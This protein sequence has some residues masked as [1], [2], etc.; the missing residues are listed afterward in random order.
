MQA[1]REIQHQEFCESLLS[2][3]SKIL[4]SSYLDSRGKRLAEATK[5]VIGLYDQLTVIVLPL[6]P[7]KDAL[8]LAAAID[9][10]WAEIVPKAKNFLMEYDFPKVS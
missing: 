6:H 7:G 8:V 4:Y 2:L 3:D 1:L 10:D 5:R 9:S